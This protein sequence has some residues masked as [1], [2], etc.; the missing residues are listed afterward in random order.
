[1]K[2]KIC[3]P[4][5]GVEMLRLVETSQA[6]ASQRAG[7]A[8][9]EGPGE[10]YRLYV[11]SDHAKMPQQ[12]PA[13]ILRCEMASVY[14]QLKALGVEKVASFPLVDRPPQEALVKA[15]QFL[16]RIGALNRDN[17]MSDT[18]RRLA[19]LP[20]PPLYA[21]CLLL[22][23]EFECVSEMLSVV[24]MMS[25]D[26]PFLLSPQGK[27]D[28]APLSKSLQHQDGDH[29]TMLSIYSQWSKHS[30]Q[31]SFAKQHSLNH[32]ALEKAATIREQLK[33]LIKGSW[34]QQISSC[35][36]PKHWVTVRRCLLKACFLQTARRDDINQTTYCTLLTR[37]AAKLHP[38][39]VLF[40]RRPPPPCVVYGELVTTSKSYLRTV[41][42]VDPSWLS[43]LCPQY[44]ASGAAGAAG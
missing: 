40:R 2:L 8:G 27:K 44:F 31:R 39:C 26:M 34:G 25:L 9:R 11:E 38:T 33:D 12:T 18:G 5:T 29:L 7:R 35:G 23:V 41:T 13:E 16:I 15:A 28:A 43:E 30:H 36:G 42:E 17:S 21:Y 24:A 3:H 32:S 4:Q 14:L 20:I 6:S 37:Q 1:M 22:S 10:V 19:V